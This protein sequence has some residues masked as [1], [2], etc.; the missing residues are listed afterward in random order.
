MTNTSATCM[1]CGEPDA[2]MDGPCPKC[3]CLGLALE[4]AKRAARGDER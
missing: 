4:L 1:T 3:G 2:P